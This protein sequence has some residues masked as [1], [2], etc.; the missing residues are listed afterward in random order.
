MQFS[1][2]K[3]YYQ[4]LGVRQSASEE[5]I[6]RAYRKLA[7]RYHPDRN[8]EDREA[9]EKRFKDVTEAYGVLM[10]PG[11]RSEYDRMRSQ[12]RGEGRE[13]FSAGYSGSSVNFEDLLRDIFNNPEA[14]RVFRDMQREFGS[15]GV[16]FDQRFFDNLFCGGR[17]VFFSGVFFF[18]P[19]AGKKSFRAS[20]GKDAAF[21][22]KPTARDLESS[23]TRPR[24]SLVRKVGRKLHELAWG[25]SEDRRAGPGRGKRDLRY[26]LT[27]TPQEARTGTEIAVSYR[28]GGKEERLSVKVPP[29]TRPG[30]LLRLRGKG[31]QAKSGKTGDLYLRVN[32]SG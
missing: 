31:L 18:G 27:V 17:G 24:E 25:E 23:P 30:T 28:R 6:K 29:G 16:R 20:S 3:D 15:R 4:I 26:T 14:S 8:A 21:S 7:F 13:R 9:A 1:H 12:G 22:G 32:I 11:K 2:H 10:D 5:E 19:H